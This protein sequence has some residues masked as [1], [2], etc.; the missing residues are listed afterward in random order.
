MTEIKNKT[1][2]AS[3]KENGKK[4]HG[5]FALVAAAVVLLFFGSFTNATELNNILRHKGVDWDL[6]IDLQLCDI[7]E[8]R[9]FYWSFGSKNVTAKDHKNNVCVL[10]YANEIEGG[11]TISECGIP[12][13]LGAILA[14]QLPLLEY[15]KETKSGNM[16]LD[17]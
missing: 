10:E 1:N 11:Y 5:I 2:L 15:C 4:E 12:D 13:S 8:R 16:L 17:N 6:P 7:T 3:N 9:T 14:S